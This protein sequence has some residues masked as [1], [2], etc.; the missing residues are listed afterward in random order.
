MKKILLSSGIIL[1]L[2]LASCSATPPVREYPVETA[3]TYRQ[4]PERPILPDV[5]THIMGTGRIHPSALS[6]FLISNNPNA[7]KD[8]VENLVMFYV[9]EAAAEGVNHDTAFAQMCL[10]TGFLRFGNLVTPDQNNFAG[11]GAIGPGQPGERF[12]EP[13]IGVRAHIQHLKAYGSTEPLNRELVNPRYR[14]VR[15]GSSPTIG[16]LAGT[17]AADPEYA[18]KINGVLERLFIFVYGTT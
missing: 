4:V 6:S 13:R 8:F 2:F 7:D 11:L 15:R 14:F 9:Q 12:S 16:G 3:G 17:W 5:P 1:V 10:E 18:S